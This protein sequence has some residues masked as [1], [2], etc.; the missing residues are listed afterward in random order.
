MEINGRE[1]SEGREKKRR[2]ADISAGPFLFAPIAE[3]YG[4]QIAYHTSQLMF[5]LFCV[6]CALAPKYV[7]NMPLR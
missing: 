5:I 3:L 2:V 1:E 6:G 4:R 7:I